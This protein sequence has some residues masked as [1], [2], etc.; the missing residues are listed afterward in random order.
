MSALLSRLASQL[1]L[2]MAT[3]AIQSLGVSLKAEDHLKNH[4]NE[5]N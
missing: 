2:A 4:F 5:K 1:M 3:F